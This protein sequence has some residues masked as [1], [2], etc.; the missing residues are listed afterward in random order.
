ML[1]GGTMKERRVP[2]SKFSIRKRIDNL[3][4]RETFHMPGLKVFLTKRETG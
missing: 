2:R 4:Q 1:E 3:S